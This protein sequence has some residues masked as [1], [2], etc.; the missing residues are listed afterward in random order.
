MEIGNDT[1]QGFCGLIVCIAG[2]NHHTL[3]RN[4]AYSKKECLCGRF[5]RQGEDSPNAD[6]E[7]AR[8]LS[9]RTL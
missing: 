7:V 2:G 6:E 4:L 1:N 5:E 8:K 3:G 9:C